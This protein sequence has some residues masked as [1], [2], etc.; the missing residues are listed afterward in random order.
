MKFLLRK[1]SVAMNC[2]RHVFFQK[3]FKN[4]FIKCIVK[5]QNRKNWIDSY[6]LSA[7]LMN[8]LGFDWDGNPIQWSTFSKPTHMSHQ[9]H[10]VK[11]K[12]TNLCVTDRDDKHLDLQ[13]RV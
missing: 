2:A 3:W 1:G 11:A 5:R 12:R 8:D 4:I 10:P 9:A 13:S 6:N 7:H